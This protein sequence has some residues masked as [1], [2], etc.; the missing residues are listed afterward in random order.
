MISAH[1][2]AQEIPMSNFE[3]QRL[4]SR[5]LF[6]VLAKIPSLVTNPTIQ[7]DREQLH[8]DLVKYRNDKLT[9]GAQLEAER[10]AVIDELAKLAT[11][12]ELQ[13]TLAPLK[14]TYKADRKARNAEL[15][16]DYEAIA[17]KR[18]EFR[19]TI[20]ADIAAIQAA[21][22][23]P[24]ALAAA[25]AKLETDQA[26]VKAALAPLRAKLE[27]DTQKWIDKIAADRAAILAA[28]EA[29]DPTLKTLVDKLE[30]DRTAAKK[31]FADDRAAI[32]ADR[33]K[34]AADIA[35]AVG[36]TS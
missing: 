27:A 3:L 10:Q 21:G 35:A 1:T 5:T 19:P 25:K 15:R 6:S 30:A 33:A 34:L 23:D 16:A 22:D 4:E 11:N 29:V 7:A 12:T 13:T 26:T 32:A 36:T 2:K 9:L 18:K 8:A 24:T 20:R 14:A 31:T 28:Q 17:A